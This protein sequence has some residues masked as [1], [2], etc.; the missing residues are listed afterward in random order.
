MDRERW[1]YFQYSNF[2]VRKHC[3]SDS[4][5]VQGEDLAWGRLDPSSRSL[6]TWVAVGDTEE[7]VNSQ[8]PSPHVEMCKVRVVDSMVRK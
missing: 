1:N 3:R 4:W 2:A 7:T 8:L 5:L 6:S